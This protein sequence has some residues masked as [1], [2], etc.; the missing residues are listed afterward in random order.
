MS[1]R[2]KAASHEGSREADA[3]RRGNATPADAVH[4]HSFHCSAIFFSSSS[5]N[6]VQ[7]LSSSLLAR[8]EAQSGLTCTAWYCQR[9]FPAPA[10]PAAVGGGGRRESALSG[11]NKYPRPRPWP[12]APDGASSVPL[13]LAT[14][15]SHDPPAR[16]Q[17][18]RQSACA[19]R[20]WHSTPGV[21]STR[22]HSSASAISWVWSRT[23]ELATADE[24]VALRHSKCV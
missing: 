14:A 23:I 4:A 8:G 22:Q 13:T 9:N 12:L 1:A 10:A 16:V 11:L 21:L 6:A 3:R 20:N 15:E 24:R 19:E 7:L 2:A 18:A 17:T 5:S